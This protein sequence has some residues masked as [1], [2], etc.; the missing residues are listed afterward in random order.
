MD[1]DNGHMSKRFR[2]DSGSAVRA[3]V[4]VSRTLQCMIIRTN[5]RVFPGWDRHS[6]R[7]RCNGVFGVRYTDER[8]YIVPILYGRRVLKVLLYVQNS[9]VYDNCAHACR[10]F[11]SKQTQTAYLCPATWMTTP[12]IVLYTAIFCEDAMIK[13]LVATRTVSTNSHLSSDEAHL[14]TANRPCSR[15]C[16]TST[17]DCEFATQHAMCATSS[18]WQ[19]LC[20]RWLWCVLSAVFMH[21]L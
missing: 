4:R 13:S 6:G 3:G 16:C 21:L 7:W 10:D 19:Q 15:P 12:N 8:P 14:C 2:N 18:V 1:T 17:E 11:Y 9:A 20:H 5:G